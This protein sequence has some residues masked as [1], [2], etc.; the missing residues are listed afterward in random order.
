[1][2]VVEATEPAVYSLPTGDSV[3]AVEAFARD[4]RGRFTSA[5]LR[6]MYDARRSE[7]GWPKLTDKALARGLRAAGWCG[8]RTSTSRG[9]ER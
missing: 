6:G 4:L 7:S 8:W 9:W 2:T 1:M 5:E 3:L